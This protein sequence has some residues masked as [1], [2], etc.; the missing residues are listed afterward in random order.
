MATISNNPFD[1]VNN[2]KYVPTTNTPGTTMPSNFLGLNNNI[3]TSNSTPSGIKTP[4][5]SVPV[6][7]GTQA[8][9]PTQ[10][11]APVNKT[12]TPTQ[13]KTDVATAKPN[14]LSTLAKAAS[15]TSAKPVQATNMATLYGA[16]GVKKAVTIGSQEAKDLQKLGYGLTPGSYKAPVTTAKTLAQLAAEKA[17]ADATEQA[18]LKSS[19]APVDVIKNENNVV[20][21]GNDVSK[22][23]QTG[24]LNTASGENPA[25]GGE[26]GKAY[27]DAVQEVRNIQD[28]YNKALAGLGDSGKSAYFQSGAGQVMQN[29]YNARLNAA[30]NKA[31]A[32]QNLMSLQNTG[33]QTQQS[34]YNQAGTMGNNSQNLLQ[35]GLATVAGQVANQPTSYNTPYTDPLTGQVVGGGMAGGNLQTSVSDIANKV[36]NGTMSYDKGVEALGMYGQAGTMALTTALGPDFNIQQSNAQAAAQ[37]A[38]TLQTG[39]TGGVV[40]KAAEGANMALDKLQADFDRLSSMQTGGIPLTNGIANWIASQLGQGELSAYENTLHDARAMVGAVLQSSGASSPTGG[41]EMAKTLLPDN[42][43]P[44]MLRE[45]ITA[46]KSLIASKVQAQTS[47]T[48][49]TGTSG[50]G[51][52][53][54]WESATTIDEIPL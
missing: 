19:I 2:Y 48:P 30:Q 28:E 13:T 47:Q 33:V 23:S 35:S 11:I 10:N 41:E 4:T 18:R 21:Q 43:T 24:L 46:I 32:L 37:G 7:M 16:N 52:I 3:T 17:T 42:M 8:K 50:G 12:L 27:Q 44:T 45:K 20:N 40:T 38:S 49:S 54:N 36:K 9:Q 31:S 25:T 6:N 39:T 15:T 22:Q 26:A 34:G 14:N 53:N 1:A 51:G 5:N 29:Q